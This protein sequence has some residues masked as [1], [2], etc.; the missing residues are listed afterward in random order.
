MSFLFKDLFWP[1]QES[2]FGG[3]SV[4]SNLVL[5]LEAL[6]HHSVTVILIGLALVVLSPLTLDLGIHSL[7]ILEALGRTA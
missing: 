2:L 1:I 6:Q 4:R 5:R 7:R 3:R